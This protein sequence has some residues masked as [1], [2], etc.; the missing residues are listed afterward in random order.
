M[1]P[2]VTSFIERELKTVAD[3]SY[4]NDELN[5]CFP[6]GEMDIGHNKT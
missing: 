6:N 4:I 1:Q 5:T 3:V 2:M